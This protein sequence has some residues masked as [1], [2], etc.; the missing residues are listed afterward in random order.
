WR[1]C[2]PPRSGD[3]DPQ[4]LPDGAQRILNLADLETRGE[5]EAEIRS[6]QGGGRTISPSGMVIERPVIPGAANA[7]S[8]RSTPFH[9]P[10]RSTGSMR[11]PEILAAVTVWHLRPK[12]Q[13]DHHLKA[14]A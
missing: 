6:P 13:M 4:S 7:S 12:L 2:S 14:H 9:M 8:W 1:D 11:T 5:D 10:T 3:T